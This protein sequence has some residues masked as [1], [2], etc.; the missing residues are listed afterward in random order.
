M[1]NAKKI[2][3]LCTIV[4][5]SGCAVQSNGINDASDTVDPWQGYN[6]AVFA[7]NEGVDK[8]VLKPV[9]TAYTKAVPS[10]IRARVTSF[11]AN[12]QDL[13]IAANNFLQGNAKDGTSDLMRV[14]VNSTIGLGGLFDVASKIDGLEKHDEDFG[15]TLAVWGVESGPYVVIPI[16]GPSTARDLPARVADIFMN[17]IN[18]IDDD[19]VRTSLTVTDAVD[20][21]ANFIPLEDTVKALSPDYYVA[22]RDFYLKRRQNLIENNKGDSDS[23]GL[24][25]ELL[26][27]SE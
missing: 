24:Y 25:E 1:N 6:R 11:F 21:R 14:L 23:D 2:L 9:S 18:H 17:P 4:L 13:P 22:L 20:T 3:Y 8:A 12:I 16:L 15:Q 27:E 5:L 10:F 7:F 26:S 19:D